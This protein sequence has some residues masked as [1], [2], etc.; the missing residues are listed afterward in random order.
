MA[1]ALGRLAGRLSRL[2][3]RGGSALPGLVAEK[4][5]PRTI[6]RLVAPVRRGVVVVTGTNGKTTTTKMLVAMLEGEGLKVVT[7]PTGSNLARGIASRLIE[8][9][10]WRGRVEADVAVFEV[11]E[12]AVRPL[13]P[14]LRPRL[15]VV[16]NLA[17]DQ[18]DRF[19][20]LATT[21]AHAAAAV[22]HAGVAV[23]NADDPLVAELASEAAEV[24]FFGAAPAIRRA[25]PHDSSL[26]GAGA[27][28]AAPPD[29]DLR[30]ERSDPDGDGQVIELAAASGERATARLQVP[31]PYNG[32]NAAAAVLSAGELGVP[33]GRAVA[34]LEATR[35]AFGRGQVVEYRGRRVKLLLVKNP[36]GFNQAIRLLAAL[37]P[38]APVLVA[39]N[40]L[41][42][43]GRDVSWLWD[44]RVEDLAAS[45][46]HFGTAGLRAF[47]MAL[48]LKYAGLPAWS[49]TDFA[50]A[51]ERFAAGVPQGETGYLV[52]T[53]TAMLRFL[54]LLRPGTSKQEAWS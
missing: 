12:A 42:A 28:A 45:G 36:A 40:D 27:E 24:R 22:R 15:L 5:D 29:L 16:T 10:S 11:D 31:G 2:L 3:G 41:D 14:R 20:E 37:P 6:E 18:L 8:V 46:H 35:P 51:L 47:D 50:A 39:I 4:V 13:A 48:R 49:E 38:G 19:G 30:L 32:Y 54:D 34:A 17:R 26:Y 23:L 7:N 1:C 44:A 21:A 52:P 9:A 33:L 53:Y 25:M 43:D